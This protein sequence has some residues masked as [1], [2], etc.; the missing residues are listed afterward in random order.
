MSTQTN[1]M[2]LVLLPRC[3]KRRRQSTV[4]QNYNLRPR[5]HDKEL[6][7]KTTHMTDSN[8]INKQI[9]IF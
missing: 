4:S 1:S 5:K 8:F 7:D 3:M 6:P 2:V 9:A